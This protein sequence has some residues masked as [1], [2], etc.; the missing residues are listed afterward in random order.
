MGANEFNDPNNRNL[1][2]KIDLENIKGR[3]IEYRSVTSYPNHRNTALG[4][5][6][7][8]CYYLNLY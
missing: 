3:Y 1:F 6:T 7:V 4:E 2:T 8:D 5:F